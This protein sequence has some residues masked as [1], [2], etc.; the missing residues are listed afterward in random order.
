M[1][2]RGIYFLIQRLFS[3]ADENDVGNHLMEI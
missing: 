3:T 1:L 2:E